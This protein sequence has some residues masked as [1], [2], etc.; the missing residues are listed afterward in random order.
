MNFRIL[1]SVSRATSPDV[2]VYMLF[3]Q[4]AVEAHIAQHQSW[5]QS[6]LQYGMG[7]AQLWRDHSATLTDVKRSREEALERLR[8]QHDIKNQNGEANL[9]IVLDHMRQAPNEQV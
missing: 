4:M 8:V 2:N 6:I 5:F 3:L 7:A 1:R 9:D